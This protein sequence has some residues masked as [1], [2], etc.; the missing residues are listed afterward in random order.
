LP[1]AE[2]SPSIKTELEIWPTN[3]KPERETVR[4]VKV[5]FT[6]PCEALF[7]LDSGRRMSSIEKRILI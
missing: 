1:I 6:L 2:K 5:A 7:H 4:N 3:K